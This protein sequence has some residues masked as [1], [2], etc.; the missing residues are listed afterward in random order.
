MHPAAPRTPVT[1]AT[2]LDRDAS[3]RIANALAIAGT[4]L[5]SHDLRTVSLGY[6]VR[7]LRIVTDDDDRFLIEGV[8]L[9]HGCATCTLRHDLLPLLRRL[10]RDERVHRIVV[11][12]DPI[13]EPE[14]VVD[15][16]IGTLVE[17]EG[18]PTAPAGD[19]VHV[20]TT[21]CAVSQ[22]RWLDDATG[23]V[24]LTEAE[25]TDM[26]DERTVAQVAV[27]QARFADALIVEGPPVPEDPY[28][29]ARLF[30]VLERLAPTASIRSIGHGHEP[31]I[32][33]MG[34]VLT[35]LPAA[36]RRGR[37]STVFDPLLDGCPPL[38]ADCGV[39]LV[40]YEADRPFHPE[41]LHDALDVLL[42]GVV[43]ARG[44][45]WLTSSSD[46]ILWLESAGGA[47]GIS[48]V[49]TW[50]AA[51]SEED[52]LDVAPAVRAMAALRW[53]EQNGDRHSS[54]VAVTHRADP[55]EIRRTLDAALV[56]DEELARGPHFLA[57]L[58]SPFGDVH[59]EPCEDNPAEPTTYEISTNEENNR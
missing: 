4:A 57:T 29:A 42:D 28:G 49:A 38:E 37:L 14:E 56:T 21:L 5:V 2:G 47:L 51:R 35:S 32:A 33:E 46:D 27:A 34:E 18:L 50:L 44:R 23:D 12:L 3:A 9:E 30:A 48:R 13:L 54:I 53:N 24:T 31:T 20:I 55:D 17:G 8:Q 10:H 15:E 52:L 25:L 41:R 45:M 16:I 22:E 43:S 7:Q 19:D 58:P 39:E 1:L 40:T 6:V 11:L 59:H 26:E 36:S